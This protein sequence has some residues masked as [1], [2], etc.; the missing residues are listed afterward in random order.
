M[1]YELYDPTIQSIQVLRLE[2]R[3][4]EKLFYL[5]DALPEYCT[6][7]LDMDPELLPEGAPVP[8]NTVQ[9]IIFN[10]NLKSASLMMIK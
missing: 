3:L 10:F 5:R 1:R 6:F 7:P 4:D 9:V 2:K 8:V